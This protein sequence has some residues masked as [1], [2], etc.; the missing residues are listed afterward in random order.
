M[1]A[2][3][4]S[5]SCSATPGLYWL[6]QN[7]NHLATHP[8]VREAMLRSIEAGEF[9]AYAPPLGF[10]A[11]RSAIVNDLGLPGAEALVT[12][13][14]VN[15]L[16]MICR[17]RC[18]PGTTLVTTD[19]T[20][21]WPCLFA[22]QQGAEVIEIP[23][24]DPA[25][26][27][28]LT[29]D[30]LKAACRRAHRD[31]LPGRSQQSARHPLHP[32]GD[33]ELR[34][35]RARLRRAAGARLH[36]SRL[37]RRP[38]LR[39]CMRRPEGAVVS[40]S[41]SKWL[42]LAGLRIGALVAAPRPD[43]GVRGQADQR[44]RRERD[45]AAR[46]AG[47]ARRQERM[48]GRGPPPSTARNKAMIHEAVRRRSRGSRC[49]SSRRTAISWCWNRIDAGIRPEALVECYRRQGIMIRQ[50]TYHTPTLRRSLREGLHL[51][52]VAVGGEVL[53]AAAG[54]W[55]R[56]R[57]RSTIVPLAILRRDRADAIITAKDGIKLHVEEAGEGTP[58]LFIHEFGGNHASWEPQLRF[59]SRRHRCITYAARGYPP[60]DVPDKRRLPI[61]KR[62][63]RRMPSPCS[64]PLG[65]DKAHIVGLSMGGFA[66]VH[67]GLRFPE[68]ALSLTV[69]G[70]GYGCEKEFEDVFSQRLARSC[71][72]FREAGREG[73]LED[74]CARARAAC[75]SRTRI[76]AAG[77][78]SPTA[79]PP[80][81][82]VGAAKTMRGVQARRPSFYDLEDGLKADG[83]CR[84]W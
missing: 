40:I 31:H 70:A 49:R 54:R 50:G 60:S 71:R 18:K 84:R 77:R 65:I 53:R 69:A 15:A 14:G 68:R 44:A 7:T 38:L 17:A 58:I 43:R 72:Q 47:R 57:A 30:A 36:L 5:T 32:R 45:R 39:R 37:R 41:F 35:D 19:P 24:Y 11:L 4:I 79:S 55:S 74:L 10:E 23:I 34:D 3:A 78:S 8:A 76:R 42:G 67:F 28:R 46:G 26:G 59:F 12:E 51:G 25:C 1:R 2:T 73:I 61:R 75:S 29:A 81:P 6:G 64:T 16:A 33:R 62:S 63:P 21:K 56:R 82:I 13:G 48:D 83:A 52:A 80:I 9:N 20:W 22:R 27:Y 66:T